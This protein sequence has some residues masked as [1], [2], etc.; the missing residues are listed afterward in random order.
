MDFIQRYG[1]KFLKR[2]QKRNNNIKRVTSL[3][4][5]ENKTV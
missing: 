1:I 4:Y 2:K 3:F 5:R